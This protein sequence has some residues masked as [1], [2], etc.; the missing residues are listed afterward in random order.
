MSLEDTTLT[1]GNTSFKGV[2][3]AIVL[4]IGSTIGGGVWTASSLYS[5]LESVEGI[6]VPDV[7]PMQEKIVLIE[8]ELADNNVSQ[9]QGKLAEL[10]T[11][12]KTILEQQDKLLLIRNDVNDMKQEIEAMK[13]TVKQA[14]LIS[15]SMGDVKTKLDK[16]EAE[17]E[18]LWSGLDYLVENPLR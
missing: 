10:G 14:E 5:R 9:L 7:S 8:Q 2:W 11:N 4:G 6:F 12:L 18:D 15:D 13:A 17:V 1:I 16:F 3:I